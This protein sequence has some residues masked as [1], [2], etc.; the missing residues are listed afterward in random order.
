M[1]PSSLL[2]LFPLVS[3]AAAPPARRI[4]DESDKRTKSDSQYYEG[5]IRVD[6]ASGRA[7]E[8]SWR[9]W[10]LGSGG[11]ARSL[12][13]FLTPPEVKGVTLLTMANAGRED[14]QWLYTPA[15]QRD[16]RIAGAAKTERFL[17]TDFTYEDMQERDLDGADHSLK[18]EAPCGTAT[19]WVIES[20][21]KKEKKSQYQRTVAWIRQSDYA[22]LKLSLEK[23]DGPVR[24]ITYDGYET[25]DGVLV[26]RT[27]RLEDPGRKSATT[28]RLAVVRF[29][30]KF[31]P[32]F[33]VRENLAILH[34][35]PR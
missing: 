15:L 23:T 6:D 26:A 19:C 17:G 7:K 30:L 4:L 2:L 28:I 32:G 21:P 20:T 12:V 11:G 10:R 24:T 34:E 3:V 16:R 1:K 29:H 8:K 22:T 35:A 5:T 33:F 9:S 27:I 13:Q 31:K 25:V 18:R 14:D